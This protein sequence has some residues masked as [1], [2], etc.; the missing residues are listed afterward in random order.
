M[1][2]IAL[3]QIYTSNHL[4]RYPKIP[5]RSWIAPLPPHRQQTP[6]RVDKLGAEFPA[7]FQEA[8]IEFDL[9][10]IDCR[11]PLLEAIE[12]RCG[13]RVGSE[14]FCFQGLVVFEIRVDARC[15]VG[16]VAEST[17]VGK[18]LFEK[19]R[20]PALG[21]RERV[22]GSQVTFKGGVAIAR[23]PVVQAGLA[24]EVVDFVAATEK[25]H[26]GSG[27]GSPSLEGIG[28]GGE[29]NQDV[30]GF[31]IA[32]GGRV[33]EEGTV[34][35]GALGNGRERLRAKLLQAAIAQIF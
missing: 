22:V 12:E 31:R 5:W 9:F 19:F 16:K 35:E 15:V 8:A 1:F 24:V 34:A 21:I 3:A 14:D 25:P 17:T 32:V 4:G 26:E 2:A 6:H 28:I 18:L 13:R 30:A 10:S 33:F 23:R 29:P 7:G 20:Q 27:N 11:C